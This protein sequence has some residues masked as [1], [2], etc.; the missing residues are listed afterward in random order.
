MEPERECAGLVHYV[1][2]FV[3][4]ADEL[5]AAG[6]VF[7]K[8]RFALEYHLAGIVGYGLDEFL[9]HVIV[10]AGHIV[11]EDDAGSRLGK[12]IDGEETKYAESTVYKHQIGFFG[13]LENSRG[14]AADVVAFVVGNGPAPVPYAA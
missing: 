11:V 10:F 3:D 13:T 12:Q 6:F 8:T 14:V 5:T 9:D 2:E 7:I 1:F 4:E